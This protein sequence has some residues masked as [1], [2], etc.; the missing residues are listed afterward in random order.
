MIGEFEKHKHFSP[1]KYMFKIHEMHFFFPLK[2]KE[3]VLPCLATIIT[4]EMET[5]GKKSFSDLSERD[6]GAGFTY[7]ENTVA[8]VC[9]HFCPFTRCF[10]CCSLN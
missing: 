1:K 3:V 2:N 8:L 6:F 9:T 7:T 5:G 4:K 10:S